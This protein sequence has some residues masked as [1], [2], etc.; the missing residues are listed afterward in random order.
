MTHLKR[1]LSP[2][3]WPITRKTHTWTVSPS[4]GPHSKSE[5]LPLGIVI[6]DALKLTDKMQ[7]T[8]VLLN[9]KK[10]LVDGKKVTDYAF[11]TGMMDVIT[12]QETGENYRIVPSAKGLVPEKISGKEANKKLLKVTK[13]TTLK[14]GKTQYAF[15]DGRTLLSD[16][17]YKINDT[18]EFD[19]KEGKATAHKPFKE[20]ET[21]IITG[22]S[23]MGITGKVEK[24]DKDVVIIKAQDGEYATIKEYVLITGE[25]K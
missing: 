4:P 6:R 14:G 7:E 18:I 19:L 20:G 3:N 8:I 22:G 10:V 21:A 11:P 5:C 2:K 15:H 25:M 1:E 24:V 16:K 17:K 23:K 12:F 9:T 13:A